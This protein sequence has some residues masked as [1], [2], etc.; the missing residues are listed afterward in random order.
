VRRRDFIAFIRIPAIR[1]P[2]SA[3]AQQPPRIYRL[4]YLS[5]AQMPNLIDA[6]QAVPREPGYVEGK[7]LNVEYRFGGPRSEHYRR[8]VIAPH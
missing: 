5:E 4:R 6:A 8:F 2:L 7:N 3:R 1:W